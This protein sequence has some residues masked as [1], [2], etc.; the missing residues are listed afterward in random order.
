MPEKLPNQADCA[1]QVGLFRIRPVI[2]EEKWWTPVISLEYQTHSAH[3]IA[4]TACGL[5][6]A[7]GCGMT[8]A[9][10]Y[11]WTYM[12]VFGIYITMI[13]LYHMLEYLCVAL[14]NP[15]RVELESFMFDPDGEN[16]YPIAMAISI[17]EYVVEC[18]F[19]SGNGSGP[20]LAS[21]AG[22]LIA[23]VG[24]SIRTLAM[25][26]AKSSFNHI[27]AD[28]RESDHTLITHGIYKYE[29]HPSYV[30]FFLWAVGLQLMLKN[31]LTVG[32]FVVALGY[33][34]I[35]RVRYEE[36]TLRQL[37]G[38]EYDRYMQQTPTCI[39]SIAFKQ[40]AL[41]KKDQPEKQT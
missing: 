1:P 21:V 41:G 8:L 36:R 2:A 35:M 31:P 27:I 26:T 7:I 3:N 30:G 29:R 22:L 40:V 4:A 38:Q 10:S 17:I 15:A 16:L 14:Y 20:G 39:P 5:G 6:V 34:F 11:G 33:F 12:G 24:Q 13:A 28:R 25:V 19:Y 23:L 32:A 9:L 37:F 18:L